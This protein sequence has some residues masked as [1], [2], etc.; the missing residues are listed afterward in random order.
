MTL[1]EIERIQQ[2]LNKE[3]RKTILKMLLEKVKNGVK[4][5]I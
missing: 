5:K 4:G 1:D 2:W 3:R